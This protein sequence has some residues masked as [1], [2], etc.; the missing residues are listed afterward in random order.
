ME[1]RII[2]KP[3][4][5]TIRA[6][7]QIFVLDWCK[8]KFLLAEKLNL[9]VS[10]KFQFSRLW[11]FKVNSQGPCC[12]KKNMDN[13]DQLTTSHWTWKIPPSKHHLQEADNYLQLSLFCACKTHHNKKKKKE[14]KKGRGNVSNRQKNFTICLFLL[15]L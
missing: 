15:C 12:Q 9:S 2:S 13:K 6:H 8:L 4:M 5:K 3:I 7:N 11:W 1:A 10:M 14:T